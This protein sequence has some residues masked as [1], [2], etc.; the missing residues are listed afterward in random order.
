MVQKIYVVL[1]LL[2]VVTLVFLCWYIFVPR[3]TND[4]NFNIAELSGEWWMVAGISPEQTMGSCIQYK[5]EINSSTA[6]MQ[7][8]ITSARNGTR[9]TLDFKGSV[10]GSS[11]VLTCPLKA[12]ARFEQKILSLDSKYAVMFASLISPKTGENTRRNNF[13]IVLSRSSEVISDTQFEIFK[14][15]LSG[16]FDDM[17]RYVKVNNTCNNKQ[18]KIE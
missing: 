9:Q 15:Q 8:S 10:N 1:S 14:K 12:E 4:N 6:W 3:Q 11:M 18:N 5:N 2:M 16:Y 7:A 17:T 13:A